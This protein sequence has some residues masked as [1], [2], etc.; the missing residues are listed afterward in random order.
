MV[1]SRQVRV[2]ERESEATEDVVCQT[3]VRRRCRL[4]GHYVYLCIVTRN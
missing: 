1:A 4:K 2:K 3:L